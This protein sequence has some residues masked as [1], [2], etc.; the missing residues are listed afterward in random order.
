MTWWRTLGWMTRK[1]L[2]RFG[3]DPLGALFTLTVPVLL[4]VL[5]SSLFAPTD[6]V[7]PLPLLLAIEEP[8]PRV[9]TL[10]QALEE[11]PGVELQRTSPKLARSRILGGHAAAA[12]ILPKGTEAVLQP[13]SLFTG[14]QVEVELLYDPSRATE[15]DILQGLLTQ[16]AMR[17]LS[18]ELASEDGRERMFRQLELMAVA[19][20]LIAPQE[21]PA[22]TTF[23]R[24]GAELPVAS[25]QGA[26]TGFPLDLQRTTLDV[27]NPKASWNPHAHYFAG[28]LTMFLLFLAATSALNLVAEREEGAL[29]R[30]MLCGAPQSAVLLGAAA[31]TAI[32]AFVSSLLVYTVGVAL[33]AI[34]VSDP[35]GLLAN[36]LAIS[37]LVGGF[38]LFLTAIGRTARQISAVAPFVILVMGFIGGSAMPSF[39]MPAWVQRLGIFLPTTW[40][41]EGLAAAT[42]RGDALLDCLAW[43]GGVV[44]F[45]GLFALLGVTLFRWR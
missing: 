22:W 9:E 13:L 3:A 12:V 1:E 21:K 15:V 11:A 16:E 45:A 44:G 41:N 43:A 42:W 14:N 4:A 28:M 37:L 38:A 19:S 29:T 23:A 31:G 34:Q 8:G 10:A 39:I 26:S 35:L 5:M 24:A 33:F 2:L 27:Y 7:T 6:E 36:L 17:M 30:V 25:V 40:A 18:E 20:P 32:I